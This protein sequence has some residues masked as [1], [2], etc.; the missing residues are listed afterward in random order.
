MSLEAESRDR[1]LCDINNA[2]TPLSVTGG[3][4]G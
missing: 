2:S 1:K 4:F 3:E